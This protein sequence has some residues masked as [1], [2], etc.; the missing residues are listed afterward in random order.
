VAAQDRDSEAY[1]DL[2]NIEGIGESMAD[3]LLGFLPKN[4]I[5]RC[6]MIWQIC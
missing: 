1:A 5:K 6:L 2:I 3:D 4:T